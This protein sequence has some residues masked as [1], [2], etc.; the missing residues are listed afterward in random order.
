MGKIHMVEFKIQGKQMLTKRPSRHGTGG[1]VYV[2]K[3][4]IGKS[5]IVILEGE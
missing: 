2:P 1:V 3:H 5:V 4:W